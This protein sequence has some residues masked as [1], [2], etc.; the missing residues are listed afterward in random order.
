LKGLFTPGIAPRATGP[1]K[2]TR[3]SSKRGQYES[4][5][6][7]PSAAWKRSGLP[8]KYTELPTMSIPYDTHRGAVSGG[9]GGVTS[10][11]SGGVAQGWAQELGDLMSSGN[12]KEAVR[13]SAMDEYNAAGRNISQETVFQIMQVVNQHAS[14]NDITQQEAAD[15]NTALMNRWLND[16]KQF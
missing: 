1:H 13:K 5:H 9:G 4:E 12:M 14:R 10:T 15:I 7:I 8:H 11:G 16:Q 6:M 2:E 3:K